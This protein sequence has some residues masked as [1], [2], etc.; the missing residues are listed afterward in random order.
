[1]QFNELQRRSREVID[2]GRLP[3]GF[4]RGWRAGTLR[5]LGYLI[6]AL[7]LLFGTYYQID[8]DEVGVVQRFGKYVRTTEPGAHFK[9]PLI[10]TVARVP[11]QRQLKAEFGFRTTRAGV[12]SE[13]EVDEGSKQEALM[14][15]GDLNVAVVAFRGRS[16]LTIS[17]AQP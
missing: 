5:K 4:L 2:V 14:L 3:P 12:R 7:I 13:F 10:E 9:V 11:V 16:P 6:V 17:P 8:A 15:T 1:M